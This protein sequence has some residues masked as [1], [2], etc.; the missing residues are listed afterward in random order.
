MVGAESK[1]PLLLIGPAGTGKTSAALCLLDHA[2]G[3]YFTATGLCDAVIASQR[4]SLT[5]N[6][7]EARPLNPEAFWR[8]LGASALVVLDELGSR[9]QASDFQRETIQK[10]LDLRE[11]RPFVGLSN[12]TLDRLHDCYDERIASRL[13]SGTVF[14]LERPDQR[15]HHV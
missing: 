15:L 12:L 5:T 13:A 3:L 6:G 9:E 7:P 4:G 14:W 2:G 10:A 1:W 8:E 11:N